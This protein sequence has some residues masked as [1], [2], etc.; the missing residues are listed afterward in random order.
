MILRR[1]AQHVTDQNWFAVV[2]DFFIVVFG[3]FLGIQIGNW[4][5]ER[6]LQQRA[7]VFERQLRAELAMETV[8][9]TFAT[10]YFADVQANGEAVLMDAEGVHVLADEVYLIKAF[11]A[12][13]YTGSFRMRYAFEDIVAA[14]V[15]DRIKDSSLW[16]TA[17]MVYTW[18]WQEVAVEET[19]SSAYRRLFRATVPLDVQR[20]ARLRCG[21]RDL[22]S[23]IPE[24]VDAFY[25]FE[26][27]VLDYPCTLSVA[28]DRIA[29]AAK[30]L[31]E[32]DGLEPALRHRIAEL[33]NSNALMAN[34]HDNLIPWRM[35]SPEYAQILAARGEP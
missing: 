17:L 13:Q 10:R 2:L 28:A 26:F 1:L 22:N 30:A 5:S 9:Y 32:A 15:A 18:T 29:F 35:S 19:Q 25:A 34:I 4:N 27:V 8:N 23:G 33:D 12:T 6:A 7:G 20:D 24:D 21:D 16:N 31:R 3:V 11:R 14:G